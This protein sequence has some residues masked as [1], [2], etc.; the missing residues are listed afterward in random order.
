M[1]H[2]FLA[3]FLPALVFVPQ[4]LNLDF[5]HLSPCQHEVEDS[6]EISRVVPFCL[7]ST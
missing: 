7:F 2:S 3:A 1:V 5:K 6:G 4:F